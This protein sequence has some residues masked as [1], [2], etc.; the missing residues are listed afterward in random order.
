[1]SASPRKRTN[2]RSFWLSALCHGCEQMQQVA[3][4]LDHRVGGG[5]QCGRNGE[6]ERLC[7]LEID[8][9]LEFGRLFDGQ[10]AGIGAL[11]NS[12]DVACGAAKHITVVRS[13]TDQAACLGKCPIGIHRWQS[14]SRG[15]SQD[16]ASLTK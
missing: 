12:V 1:M 3:S 6:A 5:E 16:L 7:G 2:S 9:K 13:I 11:K 4:L 15:Q 8:D 14:T 10:I